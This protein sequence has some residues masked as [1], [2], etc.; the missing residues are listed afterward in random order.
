M[1]DNRS[2]YKVAARAHSMA[3][4][5]DIPFGAAWQISQC[6]SKAKWKTEEEAQEVADKYGQ[7]VYRCDICDMWHCSSRHDEEE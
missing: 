3:M 5:L 6:M 2:M 1:R 4:N 7:K